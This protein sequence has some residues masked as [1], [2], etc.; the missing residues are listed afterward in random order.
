M[1]RFS[2]Q[3]HLGSVTWWWWYYSVPVSYAG[4]SVDISCSSSGPTV[5]LRTTSRWLLLMI[6]AH[7]MFLF[8][9]P[10]RCRPLFRFS[11]TDSR[12]MILMFLLQI[13]PLIYFL[14]VFDQGGLC[15]YVHLPLTTPHLEALTWHLLLIYHLSHDVYSTFR[16]RRFC[17]SCNRYTSRG[18]KT[19]AGVHRSKKFAGDDD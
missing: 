19:S 16:V 10:R 9:L 12:L 17:F 7:P 6:V 4:P 11:I 5:Y 18:T 13:L 14:L 3:V 2:I 8:L 1:F 15:Y